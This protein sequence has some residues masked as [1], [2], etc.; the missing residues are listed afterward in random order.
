MPS[1]IRHAIIYHSILFCRLYL[2]ISMTAEALAALPSDAFA[3]VAEVS[4]G[5]ESYWVL[6]PR[7][8]TAPC[9]KGHVGPGQNRT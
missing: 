9:K 2:A 4:T 5:N 8:G 3:T 6:I 1:H 7:H